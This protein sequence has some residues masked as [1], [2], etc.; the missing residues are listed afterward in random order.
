M[1]ELAVTQ[2]DR[3]QTP[4]L[5]ADWI[6][7]HLFGYIKKQE[8]ES[9]GG[10]DEEVWRREGKIFQS[11][12]LLPN[13]SESFMWETRRSWDRASHNGR[14]TAASNGVGYLPAVSHTFLTLLTDIFKPS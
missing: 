7:D 14:S 11:K 13:H 1:F 10:V 5:L 4:V 8:H 6:Q 12:T 2:R 9:R 3:N